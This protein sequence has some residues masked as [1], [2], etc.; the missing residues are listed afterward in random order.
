MAVI[1]GVPVKV[2]RASVTTDEHGN[3][4]PDTETYE[5][6]D[7]VLPAPVSTTDLSESRPN[8][9]RVD[10]MFHFPKTYKRSLRGAFIEYNN[11]RFSVVGDPQPYLDSLTPLDWD[12][13]VEAVV[14]DG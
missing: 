2:I 1:K 13:P 6:V 14:V 3:E 11:V 7:N 12:R 9:D 8:G 5:Q 4:I 10:M